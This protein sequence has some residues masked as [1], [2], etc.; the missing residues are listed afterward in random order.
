MMLS[1]PAPATLSGAQLR[2]E[3]A[4]AGR[5]VGR[6][7]MYEAGGSL[8]FPT[9]TEADR[10]AVE[11]VVAAHVPDPTW[12]ATPAEANARTLREAAASALAA[13]R[14]F[15]ALSSPTQTEVRTQV[16]SLTRQNTA[17]IRLLL[18]MFDA[19]N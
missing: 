19:T 16:Q 18:G 8:H 1:L 15:L 4:S 2:A 6:E 5:P 10:S 9:L 3:L 14:T 17:L 11:P 7:D 13:N 12:T